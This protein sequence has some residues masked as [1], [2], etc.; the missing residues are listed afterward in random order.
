MF[1]NVTPVR[2]YV[3]DIRDKM[4]GHI[5]QA[6]LT[7]ND[8]DIVPA[9]ASDSELMASIG[10][11]MGHVFLV[12]YNATASKESRLKTGL[13]IIFEIAEK[14]PQLNTSPF[15]MPVSNMVASALRN[16][17]ASARETGRLTQTLDQRILFIAESDM[18]RPELSQ[19]IRN[20]I[21]TIAD[22]TL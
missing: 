12:P 19:R 15:I 5:K 20:H 9:S 14:Q 22:L 8:A 17:L 18:D 11:R 6:G 10:T 7:I 3:S 21:N 2:P 13:D 4:F 16:Q 1:T